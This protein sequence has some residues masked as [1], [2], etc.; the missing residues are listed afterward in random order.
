MDP[1]Q[2][3]ATLAEY[4]RQNAECRNRLY[5]DFQHPDHHAAHPLTLVVLGAVLGALAAT[6]FFL[7][8]AKD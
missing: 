7:L 6:A 5:A 4:Q 2:C 8:R 1:Q 3:H